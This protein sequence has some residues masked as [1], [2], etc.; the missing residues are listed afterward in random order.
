MQSRGG[1]LISAI[2]ITAIAAIIATALAVQQRLL[3]Y[4]GELVIRSDQVYL[5][6]QSMQYA[7]KL[8]VEKSANG[9]LPLK[10]PLPT[11]KINKMVL[12]G[13]IDDEQGKFNL[14]DLTNAVNQPRFV[15]L[16]QAVMPQ[17][18]TEKAYDIAKAITAW[19]TNN[20]QDAY[21]LTLNPPYRAPQTA[22]ADISELHLVEGITPNIFSALEPY[23][24]A[25]PVSNTAINVNSASLPVLLT[26]SANLNLSKAENIIACRKQYGGFTDIA[27]FIANCVKPQGISTLNNITTSSTYFL[28]RTQ[29]KY[30]NHIALLSSLLVTQIQKDNTLKGDTVWQSFE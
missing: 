4:E 17:I 12:S 18:S 16:L 30:A 9:A 13:T 21:Y 10:T 7:A 8:A 11:I 25:L 15:A 23:V 29:A 28:A 19:L 27:T 14:N 6:L 1:A 5:N 22:M 2:F 3:I 26:T 24:T 20:S